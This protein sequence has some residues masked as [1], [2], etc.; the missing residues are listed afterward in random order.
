[1]PNSELLQKFRDLILRRHLKQVK[2]FILLLIFVR[3][4]LLRFLDVLQIKCKVI[5]LDLALL[6]DDRVVRVGEESDFGALMISQLHVVA[7][8]VLLAVFLCLSFE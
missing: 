7:L 1:M 8:M 6:L 4:L 2:V 3:L 5:S